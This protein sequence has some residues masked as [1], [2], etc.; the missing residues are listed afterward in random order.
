M[1]LTQ[2]RLNTIF[3]TLRQVH[4]SHWRAPRLAD[5]TKEIERQGTYTFRI[6]SSPWVADVTITQN[7]VHYLVNQDLPE[8]MRKHAERMKQEFEAAIASS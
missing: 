6:G 3:S 8:R 2:E 5:V 7:D 4:K 1:A